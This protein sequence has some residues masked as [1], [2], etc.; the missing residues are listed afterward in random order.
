MRTVVLQCNIQ[1]GSQPNRP[2]WLQTCFALPRLIPLLTSLSPSLLPKDPPP[3]RPLVLFP[4][5]KPAAPA[6]SSANARAP[7]AFP[8]SKSESD[9]RLALLS[10]V[11][12]PEPRSPHEAKLSLGIGS[13]R[14]STSTT[15]LKNA[16]PC[17]SMLSSSF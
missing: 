11:R 9:S 15:A 10:P 1:M 5:L 13:Q 14:T 2:E 4:N 17:A 16:D 12:T 7:S 3:P 8:A 6:F